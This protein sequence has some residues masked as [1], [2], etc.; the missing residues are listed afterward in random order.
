MSMARIC[1]GSAEHSGRG[2]ATSR[3]GTNGE[4]RSGQRAE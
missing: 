1:H 3:V 4:R 2:A